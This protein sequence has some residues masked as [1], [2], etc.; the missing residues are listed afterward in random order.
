MAVSKLHRTDDNSP[1][2]EYR[3]VAYGKPQPKPAVPHLDLSM[4]PCYVLGS[5]TCVCQPYRDDALVG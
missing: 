5:V 3:E 1:H 4:W 2:P